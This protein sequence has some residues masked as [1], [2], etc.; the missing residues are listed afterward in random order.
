VRTGSIERKLLG[1]AL[2]EDAGKGDITTRALGISK[3]GQAV[4]VSKAQGVISGLAP[5]MGVYKALS[6]AITF[7]I[8]KPEGSRVVP[9]D[10]IVI[11]KG[12]LDLILTG[13][14]TAMNILCHLSGVAT[15][16]RKL[17][18][19]VSDLPVEILDTR[20]T[21]PGLR[22]L[23]KR[24]TRAGGAIN[25]RMGLHDMYLV[26]DNHIAAAGG[27]ERA[28]Q[29]VASHKK[30]TRAKVEVEVKD[31]DELRIA[32]NYRPDFILLDN[33]SFPALKK[34]VRYARM[35]D[36]GVKLEASGNISY[37]NVRRVALS[38]VDRISVG[39]ITHSAPALDLSL[40]VV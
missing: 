27:L 21:L 39:M 23:E 8:L 35:I 38:G 3:R 17:I 19:R 5:F 37:K 15:I 1:L 33:F 16:T 36:P 40:K 28:L 29:L 25:H 14:R 31:D 10:V 34:A 13:E 4:V 30:K 26:K 6:P 11:V 7:T 18:D 20:K 2:A 32:M 12:R 24:A 9:A 22:G